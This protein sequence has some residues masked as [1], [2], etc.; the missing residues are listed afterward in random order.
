MGAF[1][2]QKAVWTSFGIALILVNIIAE[3]GEYY[4]GIHIHMLL[5]IAL[6]VGVTVGTSV[7]A[8]ATILVS[9]MDEE[10][11]LSG[12]VKDTLGADRKK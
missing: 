6:I 4:T 1:N 12:N 7:L 3:V 8:G 2:M 9:K 5:R 10:V 11:S